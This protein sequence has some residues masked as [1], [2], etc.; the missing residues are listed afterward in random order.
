[1]SD[2]PEPQPPDEPSDPRAPPARSRAP[3]AVA[4]AILVA[5]TVFA[6]DWLASKGLEAFDKAPE[7]PAKIVP[8]IV[9]IKGL[10]AQREPEL[11]IVRGLGADGKLAPGESLMLRAHL[12]APGQLALL[13]QRAGGAAEP[14]WPSLQ[15][16][17]PAGDLELDEG[18]SA[19]LLE[20]SLFPGGARLVLLGCDTAPAAQ[21][22]RT[23]AP[24]TS[25]A[26]AE[27]A[28]PG[29]AAALLEVSPAGG[30]R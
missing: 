11:H 24:L 5:L 7:P 19:L 9:S 18:G 1:M 12:S 4:V 25:A 27:A 28:F 22:L 26:A 15:E 16:T 20:P 3:T 30:P 6:V 13:A 29:C 14:I 10:I 8:R 23:R 21:Q 2:A 17:R